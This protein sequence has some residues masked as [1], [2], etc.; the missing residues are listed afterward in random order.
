MEQQVATQLEALDLRRIRRGRWRGFHKGGREDAMFGWLFGT[1][2]K[3]ER[4]WTVIYAEDGVSRL[5]KNSAVYPGP[6]TV[7]R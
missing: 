2:K 6:K 3:K 1:D 5:R 4:P 7:R